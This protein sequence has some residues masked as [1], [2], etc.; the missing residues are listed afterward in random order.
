MSVS[1]LEGPGL[2][3]LHDEVLHRPLVQLGEGLCLRDGGHVVQTEPEAE[4]LQLPGLVLDCRGVQHGHVIHGDSLSDDPL[5]PSLQLLL[6]VA[7]CEVQQA[8][9]ILGREIDLVSVEVEQEG[10]VDR[11]TEVDDVNT[12]SSTR[13]ESMLCF[14]RRCFTES[15]YIVGGEI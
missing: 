5:T 3:R 6:H 1:A 15:N 8:D 10:S 2:S 4:L 12:G 11:V 7:V 13:F 14:I 9:G